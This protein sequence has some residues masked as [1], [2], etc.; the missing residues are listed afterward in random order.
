M[1]QSVQVTSGVFCFL[2][3]RQP[4]HKECLLAAR[5][6]FRILWTVSSSIVTEPSSEKWESEICCS[7]SSD[8]SCFSDDKSWSSLLESL[9]TV[10]NSVH[11]LQT[12]PSSEWLF[13][14]FRHFWQA[15]CSQCSKG[16]KS[17]LIKLHMLQIGMLLSFWSWVSISVV[18]GWQNIPGIKKIKWTTSLVNNNNM[19]STFLCVEVSSTCYAWKTSS[20]PI[21]KL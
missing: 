16:F 7:F 11:F 13:K 2:L 5:T 18:T 1:L 14:A 3:L 6:A 12:N 4:K 8:T 10:P 21:L 20:N 17:K 15:R 19:Q 9:T